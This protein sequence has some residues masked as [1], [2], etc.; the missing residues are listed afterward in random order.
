MNL[1]LSIIG[2]LCVGLGVAGAL[3]PVLPT[4]PFLLAA[5]YLF[6]RSSPPARDWLLNHRIWGKYIRDYQVN[7]AIPLRV[8]IYSITLMWLTMSSTI[9][10]F[11][12]WWW[13]R[14][15]LLLIAVGVTI[16]IARFKTLGHKTST[17][18]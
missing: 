2:W 8:K 11:A 1:L 5:S 3:L 6:Y 13:L 7:K 18:K 14:G 12:Q 4:T 15:A 9:I 16:H 17:E 10:F